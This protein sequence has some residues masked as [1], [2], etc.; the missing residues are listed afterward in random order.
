MGLFRCDCPEQDSVSLAKGGE[1]VGRKG[2][3]KTEEHPSGKVP[4]LTQE[5]PQGGFSLM[6]IQFRQGKLQGQERTQVLQE[7][8]KPVK[9]AALVAIKPVITAF[10]ETEQEAKLGRA[11]GEPRPVSSQPREIDWV[12]DIVGV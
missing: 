5:V 1:K 12:V 2:Q 11:K 10:L 7:V 6:S 3:K 9:R 4:L 8:Q